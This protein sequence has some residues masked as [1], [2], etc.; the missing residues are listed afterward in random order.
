MPFPKTAFEREVV[1]R[2]H[3]LVNGYDGYAMGKILV[4]TDELDPDQLR[5]AFE[6]FRKIIV[7]R[8]FIDLLKLRYAR[9]I[10]FTLRS[11]WYMR[12]VVRRIT[13]NL[14]GNQ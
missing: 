7:R 10:F 3:R 8:F 1:K 4:R 11:P 9:M 2:G 6:R 13:A 14:A 12:H 5:T